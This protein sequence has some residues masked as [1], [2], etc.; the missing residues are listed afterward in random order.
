MLTWNS[1][2]DIFLRDE[3]KSEQYVQ[4]VLKKEGKEGG[5]LRILMDRHTV[6]IG[7]RW[8]RAF[9]FLTLYTSLFP[10]VYNF[11]NYNFFK[12]YKDRSQERL[13]EKPIVDPGQRREV[14]RWMGRGTKTC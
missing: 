8:G 3:S 2:H 4:Y 13:K 12:R 6:D 7:N 14:E 10:F 1:V 5:N 9:P 11:Y